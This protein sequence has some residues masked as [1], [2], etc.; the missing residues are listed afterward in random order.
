MAVP[1][2]D[3]GQF[4]NGSPEQKKSTAAA[5]DS[6]FQNVGFVYLKKHGISQERVDE[7]FR[8]VRKL[9]LEKVA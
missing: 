3:F 6:A 2:V 4:L 8:W 9:N 1:V 5:I 7:C